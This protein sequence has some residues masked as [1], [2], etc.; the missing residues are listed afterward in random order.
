MRVLSLF[1]VAILLR[2]VGIKIA[3]H[4]ED[5]R[6]ALNIILYNFYIAT[7]QIGSYVSSLLY[8]SIAV[9]YYCILQQIYY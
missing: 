1:P 4:L 8:V 5:I 6:V 2:E 3:Y 7:F 9:L